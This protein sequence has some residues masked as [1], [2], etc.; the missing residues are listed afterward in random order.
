MN[1][2]S[3]SAGRVFM[4]D[5]LGFHILFALFGV[6]IPLLISLAELI[7]I[8]RKDNDFFVM[9][10][11]WSFAM[12]TLF[13]VG[14]VSGMIISNQLTMLW[15]KFMALAGKV[16]GLPFYMEG[17]AFFI[18]AIFLGI[19]L[20]SW[21]RFKNKYTHWL[22]SIPI[23]LGSVASAF[24][25]TTA[26]AWM[27]SPAGF[28]YV[29]GVVSN[30]NP[31]AAMLNKAT[32]TETTHSIVS[33]YLTTALVFAGI[34]AWSLGFHKHRTKH[35]LKKKN[36]VPNEEEHKKLQN[37]RKKALVYTMI[38]G[39]VFA[40]LMTITGDESA[41]Y[42]ANNEPLKFAAAEM[43]EHTEAE[44]PMEIGGIEKNDQLEDAIKIPKLLSFLSFGR[45]TAVV[46]GLDDFDSNT[47][48]PLWI[49]AMFDLMVF[50]GMYIAFVVTLFFVLFFFKR[51]YS[52]SHPMLGLVVLSSPASFLALEF[53]WMV[54]EVGRQPYVIR[55]VMTVSEAFTTSKTV[56]EFGSIFPSIYTILL[57]LTPWILIRH[58]NRNKLDLDTNYFI[59]KTN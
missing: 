47:W 1:S 19:Y 11:R 28:T 49:H 14:A 54:T 36:I 5:S 10:K 20:Y 39:A 2:N 25:I 32:Y 6:G 3:L 53:G 7:A 52:F 15:P 13:V 27:N 43:A 22:C 57:I 59:N 29:N 21:D 4:G 58:Y 24:F 18:E 23:V 46:K 38:I 44:A 16:I 56:L 12:A 26:N 45:T 35:L 48:P 51:K 8:T 31:I 37:Y 30:I 33:Y 50:F 34:Y 41:R 42:V 9:A 40:L 17:F 55:G